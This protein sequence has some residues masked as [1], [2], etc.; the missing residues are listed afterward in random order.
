MNRPLSAS[1]PTGPSVSITSP[2]NEA[3]VSGNRTITAD[4]S[5]DVGVAGV[6]FYVW[7]ARA[8][9]RG[10]VAPYGADWDTRRL[11]QRRAHLTARA[12]DSAGNVT[13]SPPVNVNVVNSDF[14]QNRVLATGFD[15]PTA[16][17]SCRTADAG[18]RA[19]GARSRSCRRRTRR[20]IRPRS[21]SSRTSAPA[22]V[23]QGIFDFALDPNF[24]NNHYYYV[25]YT[26]GTPNVDRLSRFTANAD[27]SP[28]RS[29]AASWCSTRTRRPPTPSTMA[30]PSRSATTARSSSP[31]GE[32][33][34]GSP[35]QDLTSPRGKI[36]RINKDGTVPTDNPFYDGAGPT[37]TRSGPIGLRNP[38]PRLLRRA[39]RPAATSA[40]SGA[41]STSTS[42]EELELGCPRR[43]LRLAGL[44]GQCSAPC[45][46]PL[47]Y[48]EHNGPRRGHHR[49][50]RLPRHAVPRLDAGQLLLR[51]LRAEL[52]QAA[53]VRRERQ[54]QR[55]L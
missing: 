50:V 7:T 5:D 10:H 21:C 26:P 22:G 3:V 42:N 24:A 52:D 43:Q 55:R 12:R 25:F 23:Q 37:G 6:Q 30:A 8:W 15:L 33:F 19:G 36:H 4:A 1:D 17:S 39:D 9:T 53:D 34:Q 31:L 35:A 40:T 14:F 46:S 11:N 18:G 44:R 32:H 28:G 54:C 13:L 38:V 47:Y 49:R 51:R 20:R 41:T 2:A 45:T 27:A 16:M 29:L 48:Y